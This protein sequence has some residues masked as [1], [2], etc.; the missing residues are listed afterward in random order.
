M[1]GTES[2]YDF[3]HIS[4]LAFVALLILPY[5]VP[6]FEIVLIVV[7]KCAEAVS[8]DS[9]VVPRA[10]GILLFVLSL[11]CFSNYCWWNECFSALY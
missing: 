11:W 3:I 1:L 8:F 2:A 10:C 4:A 5:L 7:A 9:E 6:L